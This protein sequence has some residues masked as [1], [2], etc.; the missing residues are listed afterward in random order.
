MNIITDMISKNV[1]V[2]TNNVL[3]YITST[4]YPTGGPST[5][6]TTW[7]IDDIFAASIK[8]KSYVCT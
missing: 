4:R 6:G 2:I 1:D 7:N 3:L 5:K 8:E